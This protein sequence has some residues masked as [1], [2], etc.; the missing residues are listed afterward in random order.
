MS[1]KPVITSKKNRSGSKSKNESGSKKSS[2][3]SAP[4]VVESK[5]DSSDDESEHVEHSNNDTPS[6]DEAKVDEEHHSD[7]SESEC[8]IS[9]GS[10]AALVV[11]PPPPSIDSDTESKDEIQV[12]T[13][14][15]LLEL[16]AFHKL[17]RQ[18]MVKRQ[19]L[20][21]KDY[22]RQFKK[23]SNY[24]KC[25]KV[26]S[27][28]KRKNSSNSGFMK[29]ASVKRALAEFLRK[30]SIMEE[31]VEIESGSDLDDFSTSHHVR[32]D[33]VRFI[34]KWVKTHQLNTDA[35]PCSEKNDIFNLLEVEN[36]DELLFP[37]EYKTLNSVFAQK[38]LFRPVTTLI[39]GAVPK[40]SD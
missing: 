9:M 30:Y 17:E 25:N 7:D 35:S 2:E 23:T 24:K 3:K 1:S 12:A 36:D 6:V 16:Q 19:D 4:V 14:D 33:V 15:G 21:E 32:I 38:G 8:E 5:V 37:Y 20:E 18:N 13:V 40:V 28:V 10:S 29:P 31:P 39:A 27:K 22:L 11:P 26:K 34:W